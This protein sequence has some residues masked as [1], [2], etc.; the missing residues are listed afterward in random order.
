[1]LDLELRSR[2]SALRCTY[3]L[4]DLPRSGVHGCAGCG[5]I[6]HAA[7]AREL[8]RCPT[9]GCEEV[10]T[11]GAR[12]TS[13]SEALARAERIFRGSLEKGDAE[14][15]EQAWER[16][17]AASQSYRERTRAQRARSPRGSRQGTALLEAP[18][19]LE[20]PPPPFWVF[21]AAGIWFMWVMLLPSLLLSRWILHQVVGAP[22][23]WKPFLGLALCIDVGIVYFVKALHRLGTWAWRRI[24]RV[25]PA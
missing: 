6:L 23:T 22:I 13:L 9:I 24:F 15:R 1:M 16:Y 7:C 19:I 17:T 18:P 25:R 12:L 3:C 8:E 10:I 2:G 5:T 20:P 14:A 4:D 11:R 21:P